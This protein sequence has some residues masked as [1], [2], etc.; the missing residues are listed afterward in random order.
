LLLSALSLTQAPLHT[1]SPAG[2]AHV[3][4]VHDAPVAQ[5]VPH[6]PQLATVLSGVSQP[7]AALP[8]QF[9]KP[10]R[11]DKTVHAPPA[12]ADAAFGRLHTLPHRPQLFTSV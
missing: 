3:P 12:H 10:G 7:L 1:V 6:A 4:L 9:P 2:H 5:A 11:H 8:S